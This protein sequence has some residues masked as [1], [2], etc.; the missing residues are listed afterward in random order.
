MSVEPNITHTDE[1][2]Y[3]RKTVEDDIIVTTD[4]GVDNDFVTTDEIVHG[5]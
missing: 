3:D 5:R 2:T 4:N 1:T